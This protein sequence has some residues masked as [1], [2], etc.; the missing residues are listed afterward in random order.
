MMS[1]EGNGQKSIRQNQRIIAPV[2][3]VIMNE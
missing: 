1:G 2:S 3:I